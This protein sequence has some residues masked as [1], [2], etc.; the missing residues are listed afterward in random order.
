MKVIFYTEGSIPV[1]VECNTG[2]N[3]LDVVFLFN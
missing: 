2:D 1:S 3:L